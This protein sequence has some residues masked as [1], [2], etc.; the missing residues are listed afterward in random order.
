MAG[1]RIVESARA[2]V[3]LDLRVTGRR[4]DGY[5]ELDS[6]VVFAPAHDRLT[7][8]PA[9]GLELVVLGPTAAEQAGAT[10]RDE[11]N[12]VLRAARLLAART[13]MVPRARL[14]LEKRLP[15]AAGLGG[16]SA[17]AAA[18]IR[19]LRRLWHL[20]LGPDELTELALG[21][22]ADVPVCLASTPSRLRGIG[23][24]LDPLADLPVLPLLLVNPGTPV[25]TPEVFR[26]LRPPMTRPPRP[27]RPRRPSLGQFLDWLAQSANDLEGPAASVAP[28]IATVLDAL[29]RAPCCGLARMSGSG[30]TCWGLFEDAASLERAAA[31]LRAAQPT[32]WI[33][34]GL[35]EAPP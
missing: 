11:T 30:A 31:R 4:P 34:A 16:G 28:V 10:P 17:D 23:E 8:E 35:T 26:R 21:L 9:A 22:G 7:A 6:I 32:W 20:D 33:S 14:T 1:D 27:P 15:A 12:S 25:S 24:R 18:A 2:K 19:A 3:N 13:G 5:H 29:R